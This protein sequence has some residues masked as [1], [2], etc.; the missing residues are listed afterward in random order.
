MSNKFPM[1]SLDKVEVKLTMKVETAVAVDRVA[2]VANLSRAAVINGYVADA[3]KKAKVTLTADDLKRIEEI[4]AENL[5]KR[6]AMKAKKG[7]AK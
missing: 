5:A 1:I 2:T 7:G 3:L 4:K 6:E